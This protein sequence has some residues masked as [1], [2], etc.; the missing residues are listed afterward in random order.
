VSREPHSE[1]LRDDARRGRKSIRMIS[2]IFA[3]HGP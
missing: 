1:A 2:A 3:T